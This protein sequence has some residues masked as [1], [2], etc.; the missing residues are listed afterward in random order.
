MTMDGFDC[1]GALP[2]ANIDWADPM[3]VALAAQSASNA[4]PEKP[5]MSQTTKIALVGGGTVLGIVLLILFG[6]R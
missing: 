3:Q 5:G 4:P 2:M 6:R 1:I